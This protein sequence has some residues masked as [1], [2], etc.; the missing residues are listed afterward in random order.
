MANDPHRISVKDAAALTLRWRRN[1]PPD[2]INGARFDR[3][4]FD[5]LL[6][7]PGCQG[8]RIYLGLHDP[9]D[10]SVPKGQSMWTFVVIG[11]DAAGNDIMFG[12]DM[13]VLGAAQQRARPGVQR[14]GQTG[15]A[16]P[17]PAPR[18]ADR[19]AG[20]GAGSRRAGSRRWPSPSRAGEPGGGGAPSDARCADGAGGASGH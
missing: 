13:E 11:T 18:A 4:T 6:S 3:V 15:R 9:A 1:R 20:S 17:R 10:P 5:R 19:G 14:A 12:D 2:S 7:Q 8:I 16:R